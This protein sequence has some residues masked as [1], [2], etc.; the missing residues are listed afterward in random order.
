VIE[1]SPAGVQAAKTAGCRVLAVTNSY[2]PKALAAADR[3][4]DS[5]ADVSLEELDC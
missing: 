1:D 5:L 4:V 3:I 2:P